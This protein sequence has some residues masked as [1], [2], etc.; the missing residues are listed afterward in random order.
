MADGR[1]K[2]GH[3]LSFTVSQGQDLSPFCSSAKVMHHFFWVEGNG[4][5]GLQRDGRA[6]GT[7]TGTGDLN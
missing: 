1:A 2:G 7:V 4:A 6:W 3:T 5:G